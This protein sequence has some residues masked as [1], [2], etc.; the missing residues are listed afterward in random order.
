M[1]ISKVLCVVILSEAKNLMIR[2]NNKIW[3]LRR[4]APQNDMIRGF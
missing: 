2:F 3:I 4:Y 1:F